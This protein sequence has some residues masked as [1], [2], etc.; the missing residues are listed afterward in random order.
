MQNKFHT[1]NVSS[2][3]NFS[4]VKTE[5]DVHKIIV[6]TMKHNKVIKV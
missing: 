2:F 3:K 5:L 6:I 4:A 1:D